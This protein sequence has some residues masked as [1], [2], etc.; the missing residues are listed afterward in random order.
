MKIREYKINP[1]LIVIDVQNGFVSKGGSYDLLKMDTSNYRAVIPVIK[2]LIEISRA[3]G[4]PV[5]YTQAVRESSGIDLLTKTHKILPKS[6]EERIMRKPICV[7]GTWD[8]GIVDDIKPAARDHIVIKR[9]DSAFHDTEINVWLK[10]L[11]ID[12]LIFSGIDTSICVE[13][14]LR[15]AFNIGYDIILISDATASSN[16]KH[17][18]STLDNVRGYYGL[19]MELKEFYRYL[20]QTQA[21][22]IPSKS[23]A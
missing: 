3:A 2:E 16:R 6:R 18:E 17:Y 9:R 15:E 5:F 10:S 14:S 7:R 11:G 12:T 8:A 19:V 20:P 22:S 21:N 23:K 13:T 4:I 1:A